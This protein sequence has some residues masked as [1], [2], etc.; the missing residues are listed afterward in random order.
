MKTSDLD[1]DLPPELVAQA[2]APAREDA[3]LLAVERSTGRLAH[4]AARDLPSLLRPGDLLVLND[5]RV[6]PVRLHARRASGGAVPVLLLRVPDAGP[7]P[8]LARH[9]GRLKP[10]EVLALEGAPGPGLVVREVT[11]GGEAVLE[12]EGGGPWAGVLERAGRAPLPPYI[13]RPFGEDPLLPSDR[14]RYQTTYARVPG[15]VA[16]PTAG[17]HLTPALFDEAARRGAARAFVTL[18]VG[19]G[20]FRPVRTEDLDSHAL[21][22][23]W[24][25]V[26]PETAEAARAA[27]AAGGR[28]VAVGTTSVRTLETAARSG[29]LLPYE[30]PSD[31]FV[32]PPYR[33]RAVDAL[34]TNFHLPRSTLLALVAAFAGLPL[35]LAAYR[36]AVR[37]RYRFYSYGDACFFF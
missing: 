17:L 11:E 29:E 23:E 20:T 2:P 21:E 32:R 15:S 31:L 16:A 9:A 18:H 12:P 37:L 33:F 10:G 4:L 26:P 7:A 28:V 13:R 35:V 36:E 8:A 34:L 27:K 6:L 3:R 25:R 24:C 5:T 30:G 19:P 1:Y 14:E 22:A